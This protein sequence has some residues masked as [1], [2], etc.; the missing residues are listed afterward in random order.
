MAAVWPKFLRRRITL[1]RRVLGLHLPEDGERAVRAAVV[2]QE[3]L[4]RLAQLLAGGDELA[5]ELG[6]AAAPR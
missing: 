2:D 4:E 6:E 3:D 1:I 5:V